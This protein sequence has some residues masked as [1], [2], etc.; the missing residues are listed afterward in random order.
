[1][2]S[3]S[4]S[5]KAFNAETFVTVR[6]APKESSERPRLVSGFRLAD[7]RLAWQHVVLPP[8]RLNLNLYATKRTH[9]AFAVV[10]VLRHTGA[11]VETD[12]LSFRSGRVVAEC[13]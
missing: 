12:R 2:R 8:Y 11:T 3:A 9:Y 1:M 7:G 4:R 10:N 13:L 5:A 6:A